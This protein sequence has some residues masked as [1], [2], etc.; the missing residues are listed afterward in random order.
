MYPVE[1]DNPYHTAG[2][3]M[4]RMNPTVKGLPA[5]GYY[6]VHKSP[7]FRQVEGPER[8]VETRLRLLDMSEWFYVG[9]IFIDLRD[10]DNADHKHMQEVDIPVAIQSFMVPKNLDREAT[11]GLLDKIWEADDGNG[12]VLNDPRETL[13]AGRKIIQMPGR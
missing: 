12:Q 6:F 2:L 13:G 1:F 5:K 8:E 11:M 7:G 3:S 9:F 10:G 4:V